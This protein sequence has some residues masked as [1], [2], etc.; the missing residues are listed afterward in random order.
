MIH[1]SNL[2]FFQILKY[3]K[4]NNEKALGA[5]GQSI[6]LEGF[7][8]DIAMNIENLGIL[9]LRKVLV[10]TSHMNPL[11]SSILLGLSDLNRLKIVMDFESKRVKFGVG[12]NR[13]KW[14]KMKS[15]L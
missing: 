6:P 1:K 8:V 7:T 11:E 15:F 12:P 10:S 3:E 4:C 2:R 14:I 13:E 9:I 5:G